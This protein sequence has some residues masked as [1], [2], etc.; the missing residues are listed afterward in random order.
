M[1]SLNEQTT[2]VAIASVSCNEASAR[3]FTSFQDRPSSPKQS[4]GRINHFSCSSLPN[5]ILSTY[6][7]K[8]RVNKAKAVVKRAAL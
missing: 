4:E 8:K 1:S 7:K 6:L 5:I 3:S 2:Y